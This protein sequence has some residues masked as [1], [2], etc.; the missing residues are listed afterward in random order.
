MQGF[1]ILSQ[2]HNFVLMILSHSQIVAVPAN[3]APPPTCS[4]YVKQT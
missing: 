1:P 2:N 3:A 4:L